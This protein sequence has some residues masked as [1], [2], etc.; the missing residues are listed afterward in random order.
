MEQAW[1]RCGLVELTLTIVWC[2]TW[3]PVC[4]T[5][6]KHKENWAERGQA[7]LVHDRNV[8]SMFIKLN[9]KSPL[10]GGGFI[11]SMSNFS[12]PAKDGTH[13]PWSW[14]TALT[15]RMQGMS[16]FYL[17]NLNGGTEH[18]LAIFVKTVISFFFSNRI[19]INCQMKVIKLEN[20]C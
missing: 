19:Q 13:S 1:A 16:P 18:H 8:Y 17:W 7:W 2:V 5:L 11:Y 12:S 4:R 20:F 10:F 9:I 14:S 6:V 15:T 3:A